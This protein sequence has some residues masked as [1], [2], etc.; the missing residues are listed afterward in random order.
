[1][2]RLFH[3]TVA[4]LALLAAAQAACATDEA[5]REIKHK[6]GIQVFIAQLED[7]PIVKAR[8]ITVIPAPLATV[9]DILD[10]NSRH[11]EWVPFLLESRELQSLSDF[12]RLEYNRFAAPWPASDRDFL[13]RVSAVAEP[14]GRRWTFRMQSVQS[15][16]MAELPGVV[17]G[18]LFESS[19]R[20]TALAD[21]QTRLELM[22]HADPRGWVPVWII[23]IIQEVWPMAVLK[24]LR[25][26][27][28]RLADTHPRAAPTPP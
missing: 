12:D 26:Q 24:G 6:D 3:H 14:D 28:S 18:Q 15:P 8:A 20:L 10:D 5:W 1:M 25:A 9:A 13:Y 23:N 21:G 17:R 19:Y 2:T 27:A 4:T 11:G 7:T 22:F 16:L